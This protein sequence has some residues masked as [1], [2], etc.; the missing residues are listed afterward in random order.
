[1]NAGES[2]ASDSRAVRESCSCKGADRLCDQCWAER[3]RVVAERLAI[4]G[5]WSR[6]AAVTAGRAQ[7][8]VLAG[9]TGTGDPA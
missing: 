9:R 1:M 3:R 2:V 8:S 6:P 5:R 4:L 7:T